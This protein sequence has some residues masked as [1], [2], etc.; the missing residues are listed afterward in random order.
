MLRFHCVDVRACGPHYM[1]FLK[2]SFNVCFQVNNFFLYDSLPNSLEEIW[3]VMKENGRLVMCFGQNDINFYKK[4]G[5][6]NFGFFD[7]L[8]YLVALESAGFVDI[9]CLRLPKDNPKKTKHICILAR[10]PPCYLIK[11]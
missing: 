9:Q 3:R 4:I 7:P 11:D 1:P 8:D 6:T 10:K 2:D 5:W